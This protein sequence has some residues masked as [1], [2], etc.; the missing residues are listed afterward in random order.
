MT[1]QNVT[2]ANIL[3]FQTSIIP[4]NDFEVL[5]AAFPASAGYSYASGVLAPNS[6]TVQSYEAS[7]SA[8]SVGAEFYVTYTPN[9]TATITDPTT[10]LHWIQ[11]VSDNYNIT[12][13][14]GYGN[15]ELTVDNPHSPGGRSPYYDDGGAA[16]FGSTAAPS[17]VGGLGIAMY[18]FPTRNNPGQKDSWVADLFLVTG[19]AAGTP[20]LITIYNGVEWGW[21][22]YPVPLPG[23]L[24]LFGPG[25]AALAAIR[26][27]FRR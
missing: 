8:T 4:M 18:D 5:A 6:L 15:L 26:R 9:N 16:T 21:N 24:L 17:P 10:N 22:N 14:P 11:I 19:P 13:N 7:G 12:N 27:K 1:P 20:G 25:L 3:P 23:A 2:S